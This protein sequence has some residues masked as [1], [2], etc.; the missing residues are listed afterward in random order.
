MRAA[1]QVLRVAAVSG[2][3]ALV[4]MACATGAAAQELGRLRISLE[5]HGTTDWQGATGGEWK[6][7]KLDDSHSTEVVLKKGSPM[8]TNQWDPESAKRQQERVA[9][10]QQRA[11]ELQAQ[12]ARAAANR[13]GANRPS[14]GMGNMDMAQMMAMRDKI[15][16]CGADNACKQ[17]VAMQMMQQHAA[18]PPSAAGGPEM[19]AI[20]NTCVNERHFA[21][22]T[23]E[24]QGCIEAEGKKVEA[25]MAPQ[26]AAAGVSQAPA[27]EAIEDDPEPDRYLPYW[28]HVDAFSCTFKGHSKIQHSYEGAEADVSGLLKFSGTEVGEG[29]ADPKLIC[30]YPIVIVDTKTNLLWSPGFPAVG[31]QVKSAQKGG[32]MNGHTATETQ[33]VYSGAKLEATVGGERIDGVGTWI[34]RTLSGAP[35]SGERVQEFTA[36][37]VSSVSAGG[38]HSGKVTAK[39]TWSFTKE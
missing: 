4:A 23:K 1:V 29:D 21:P 28:S 26:A 31:A 25:R 38:K 20:M 30:N 7:F 6:K 15:A 12:G 5:L 35:L 36:T 19:Q 34:F 24:F 13:G 27:V 9:R 39:L 18:P 14:G 11:T 16:A 10:A 17:Q 3:V 32:L 33:G 22:G 37:Q 8:N 2:A